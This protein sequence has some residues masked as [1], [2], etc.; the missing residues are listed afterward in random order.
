[1][2]LLGLRV[3]V[4]RAG[5]GAHRGHLDAGQ[6]EALLTEAEVHEAQEHLLARSAPRSTSSAAGS[7]DEEG[8]DRC[9]GRSRRERQPAPAAFRRPHA[10]ACPGWDRPRCRTVRS[11]RGCRDRPGRSS[12]RS[13]PGSRSSRC[14]RMWASWKWARES[15]S[16]RMIEYS[17]SKKYGLACVHRPAHAFTAGSSYASA[18]HGVAGRSS[19]RPALGLRLRFGRTNTMPVMPIVTCSTSSKWQWYMYVPGSSRP[20]DVGEL[21][22]DRHRD[23]GLGHAVVERDRVDGTR[24]SGGCASRR[25]RA[26]AADR[27][28]RG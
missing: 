5:V 2:S 28:W 23:R 19:S 6:R 10:P 15:I 18:H 21:A 11:A 16:V 17:R 27:G 7:S 20:V 14:S 12:T 8:P 24:A 3:G 9:S 13:W 25:G 4:E 1:M 22:P 26:A